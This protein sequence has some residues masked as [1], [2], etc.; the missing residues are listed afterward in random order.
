MFDEPFSGK[1]IRIIKS[2]VFSHKIDFLQSMWPDCPVVLVHRRDD[3]CLGW[4]LMAGG[5]DIKYPNYRPYYKDIPTMTQHIQ[6]QNQDIVEAMQNRPGILSHDNRA[7]CL[8]LF[9]KYPP[10]EYRQNYLDDDIT[11]KI[12]NFKKE[13]K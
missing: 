3:S 4:W 5:F 8:N 11:V 2:H 9:I 13:V 7:V 6:R 1:G 12:L 10:E